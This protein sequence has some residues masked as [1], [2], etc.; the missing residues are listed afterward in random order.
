MTITYR[1]SLTLPEID[2]ILAHL[3]NS[4]E[5]NGIFSKLVTFKLKA[6]HGITKASH[7][8]TGSQSLESKLGLGED[9]TVQVLLD[10]Y[11][12][13]PSVLSKAQLAKVQ[14]HRYVNDLMTAQEEKDF[15][16]VFSPR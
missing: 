12:S 13:N 6:Q 2:Y 14:H 16:Q 11:N 10:A 5:S 1:P 8:K 3:P 15:E 4:Q 9:T 7:I